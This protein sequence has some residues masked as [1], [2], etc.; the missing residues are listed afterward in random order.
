M[1][2][3]RGNGGCGRTECARTLL[4]DDADPSTQ[5]PRP[6]TRA[7]WESV[8][9]DYEKRVLSVREHDFRGRIAGAIADAARRVHEGR[10]AD[11]GCGVGKFTS[12]LADAFAGVEACDLSETAMEA[13]RVRCEAF[14][15]VRFHRLD[16]TRD[17]MP[18]APV[19]CVLCVNVLLMPSLDER[20]RAWRAVS[21]QVDH[22]GTL[23]L[24][25]PSRE[26]ILMEQHHAVEARLEEGQS[27]EA[28]LATTLP[29]DA[30]RQELSQDVHRLDGVPTKHYLEEELVALLEGHELTAVT[31]E[32]LRY[33]S[34]LEGT[35]LP[36]WDWLAM[37]KRHSG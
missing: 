22:G 13:T 5:T 34:P 3:G 9:E 7:Y 32:K 24:V 2:N 25:V 31:T 20:L 30:T 26:S 14:T 21:N 18:F 8:A 17:A 6:M 4:E 28:A 15:N 1:A 12:L 37:A 19:D 11:L 10:A 16:L 23:V 33:R 36:C 29:P 27:C 35:P